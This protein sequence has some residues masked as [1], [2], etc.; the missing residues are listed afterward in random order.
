MSCYS[1]A[2]QDSERPEI[3]TP[4]IWAI[5][6]SSQ[7]WQLVPR[8]GDVLHVTLPSIDRS[9]PGGI[10]LDELEGLLVPQERSEDGEL[11]KWRSVM[12]RLLEEEE[13]EEVKG[14][15]KRKVLDIKVER[16]CTSFIPPGSGTH[17]S[18]Q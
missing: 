18:T 7:S 11:P 13:E 8:D 6:R 3:L 9:L 2:T 14:D 15:K 10:G 1:N 5:F 12:T 17:P 16:A 4:L